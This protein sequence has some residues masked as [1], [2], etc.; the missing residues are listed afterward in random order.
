MTKP[1]TISAY[2]Q[3]LSTGETNSVELTSALL[4]DA[5]RRNTDWRVFTAIY[6][7]FALAAAAES[8]TR[9]KQQHT[10]GLLDGVPMA[11]KDNLHIHGYPT[12]AGTAYDFASRF[13]RSAAVVRHLQTAGA[14]IIGHCNMDEAALGA[15]S[16]NPHFG[17][18]Y[19]PTCPGHT[20]GGSSGGSAA[21]VAAGF[22]A[23]SLGT[24]T[25][26]SVRIPAA[27][28][29]LWGFKPS[30][31]VGAS[32]INTEGL[33]PLCNQLDTIG[34]LTHTLDDLITLQQ[35]LTNADKPYPKSIVPMNRLRIGTVNPA[36]LTDCEEAILQSYK[37]LVDQLSSIG[38]Q[39]QVIK[40]AHWQP[41][42]ARR[43]G[44]VIT[45][46]QASEALKA[47]LRDYSQ[48]FSPTFHKLMDYGQKITEVRLNKAQAEVQ[49]V[50]QEVLQAFE[51]LDLLLLPT[52]PQLA[53]PVATPPPDNQADFAALANLT[54]CP[55]IAMPINIPGQTAKASAQLMAKPGNDVALLMTTK[56]IE[57]A[58]TRY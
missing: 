29:E 25:M 19:N 8:D 45:E 48:H 58:I 41:G 33:V 50:T 23:A 53:F 11:V 28:C 54:G 38:A 40:L 57:L 47:E 18:C 56:M 21:A 9:R 24:D 5:R 34:P 43:N 42:K 7:D 13:S 14:V 1:L 44:L 51:N 49:N 15:C 37:H 36:E 55:A 32:T 12:R 16:N 26:G 39:L 35:T 52:A 22:V 17:Q 27:Y 3:A 30:N 31:H 4:N 46:A 6:E 2:A 10:L 20:P